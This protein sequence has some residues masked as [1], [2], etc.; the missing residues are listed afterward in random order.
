VA[1]L[2]SEILLDRATPPV[3]PVVM[4]PSPPKDTTHK[5][6][7]EQG[8][9][10]EKKK[11][12]SAAAAAAA[13]KRSK[14]MTMLN[15]KVIDVIGGQQQHQSSLPTGLYS[16]DC[17]VPRI[18]M[19]SPSPA[20]GSGGIGSRLVMTTPT[21]VRSFA[22][23]AHGDSDGGGPQLSAGKLMAAMEAAAY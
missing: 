9:V 21:R 12:T 17:P 5:A 11:T 13:A 22:K 15:V 4:T 19:P 23:G 10:E 7:Q 18:D 16:A 14:D 1:D 3:S 2:A 20:G 8:H 6:S